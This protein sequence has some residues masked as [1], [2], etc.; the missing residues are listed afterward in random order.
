METGVASADPHGLV[1]M[2]LEGAISSLVFARKEIDAGNI[3]AKGEA[4]SKAIRII[5]ELDTSLNIEAGGEIAANLRTLYDYMG[6]SLL[7]ANLKNDV[8]K[9]VEV[10]QLLSELK[11][12]WLGI[13]DE[14]RPKKHLVGE[15]T[16]KE[17]AS[18][19][20]A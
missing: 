17:I 7:E 16:S 4:I 20:L 14:V 9:L 3:S 19:G 6:T 13:A 2:L 5:S 15:K 12:A 10:V 8:R 11:T 1:L 18:Y